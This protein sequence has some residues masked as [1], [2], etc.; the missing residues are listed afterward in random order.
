[1]NKQ[2]KL[3]TIH[4]ICLFAVLG[5][6]MFCSKLIMELLPNIHLLGMLVMLYTVLFRAKALFPIYIYVMIN[7]I[8]AGFAMWWLPYLYIWTILWGITMLLPRQM[9]K[10]VAY[11]VYPTVCALHGFMFGIL[12]APGQ[13]LMYGFNFEQT[14]AW[15]ASGIPFDVIH[16]VSNFVMGFLVFPLSKTLTRLLHRGA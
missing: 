10:K 5:A 11:V 14:L 9:S 16:G 6:L 8:Y 3:L 4:E 12:Y 2:K 13:A 1:M 7:G 15:I